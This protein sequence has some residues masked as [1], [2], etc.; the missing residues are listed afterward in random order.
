MKDT[1]RGGTWGPAVAA[2]AALV[3]E[4]ELVEAASEGIGRI[5]WATSVILLWCDY[6]D[7]KARRRR[8][9]ARFHLL[10]AVNFAGSI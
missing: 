8:T 6:Y 9:A 10:I 7:T 5:G 3:L 2:A 4:L 1:V